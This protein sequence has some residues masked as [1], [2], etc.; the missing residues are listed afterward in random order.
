MRWLLITGALAAIALP[1]RAQEAPALR[2]VFYELDLA[3]DY[4]EEI[5]RGSVRLT[6][7]NEGGAPAAEIP[8]LLYRLMRL[9]SARDEA[10]RALT[11]TQ[12]VQA[13]EDVPTLQANVARVTLVEPLGPGARATIELAY[14]GYLLGYREVMGYVRDRI[15]PSFTI[16]RP[17]SWAYPEIGVPSFAARRARGLVYFDYRA[18][19]TVP[20]ALPVTADDGGSETL[21]SLVVANGGRL[22]ERVAHEDGTV[23]WVYENVLPAWRMDFA[24]APY[25]VLEEGAYRTYYLPE[26]SAAAPRVH[27]AVIR[28]MQIY[29]ER[30]GPL[31]EDPPFAILEIPEG[32]GSQADVTSILQAA[33]AFA[34]ST[35]V[36]EIYHEVSHLWNVGPTDVSPR[37][38]EGLASFLEHQTA[39]DIRGTNELDERVEFIR[40]WLLGFM[41]N[42]P[43][44]AAIPMIEYGRR[45]QTDLAY[46]VGM[47]MFDVLHRTVGRESFDRVIGGFYR[48]YAETGGSTDD[49]VR[50]ASEASGRDLSPLFDDWMYSTRW[51][52]RLKEGENTEDFAAGYRAAMASGR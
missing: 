20:E 37:W 9:T 47:L 50:L 5:V 52:Q 3:V 21:R 16:L 2:P 31:R 44:L 38:N 25:G 40:E 14:E 36:N 33:P 46:S 49:F 22:I 23:T 7:E 35:R 32:F 30:F 41:E 8:L 27:A 13:I 15:D 19:I 12:G 48:R 6:L 1:A 43:E 17:D 42:R 4:A 39:G 45:G 29:T 11:V 28:A 18:R 26:D 24:I 51:Y 10:G 34:D